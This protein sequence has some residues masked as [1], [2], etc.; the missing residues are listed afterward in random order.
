MR[1]LAGL[2]LLLAGI[3]VADDRVQ[4][5]P[6]IDTERLVDIYWLAVDKGEL[7]IGDKALSRV[8]IRPVQVNYAYPL[9]GTTATV[10]VRS[11]MQV[12]MLCPITREYF[13]E[14]V[15]AQLNA[16]GNIVDTW[17]EVKP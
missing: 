15:T 1:I 10:T 13:V 16:D 4:V 11:V 7:R 2:F 3:A 17:Y 6:V 9:D 14:S 12:R 5:H 8:M